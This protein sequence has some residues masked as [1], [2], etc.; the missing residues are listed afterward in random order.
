MPAIPLREGQ[1]QRPRSRKG[2][3][4]G[5]EVTKGQMMPVTVPDADES[6]HPIAKNL[7]NALKTSGQSQYYQNSDWAIAYSL[8]DDLSRYKR[9]EDRFEDGQGKGGSAMKLTAIMNALGDLMVTEAD[10]RRIH[11]ELHEPSEAPKES[12]D[13]AIMAEY[14]R[15]VKGS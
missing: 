10:R 5:Y 9:A 3:G 12:P 6:W 2:K 15:A 1:T 7:F 8:C 4:A 11:I 13:V 14:K